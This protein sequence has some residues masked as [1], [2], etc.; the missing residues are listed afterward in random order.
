M[1]ELARSGGTASTSY[2]RYLF[3]L[4]AHLE[5]SHADVDAGEVTTNAC[6]EFL[7]RWNGRSASTISSIRSAMS[8]LFQWL[9]LEGEIDTN[10][11]TRIPRPRRLRPEDLDVVMVTPAD[12]ERM[13]RACEDW[14]EFLKIIWETVVRVGERAGVR[15]TV[16]AMRRALRCC[17]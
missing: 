8:G 14:Q 10:P 16:H 4:V 9:Y 2:E 7:D 13:L 5:Q 6:R 11:M 15:A 12:V 17:S 1:G 3:K